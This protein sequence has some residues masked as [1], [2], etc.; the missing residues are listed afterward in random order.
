MR[1]APLALAALSLLLLAPTL[2]RSEPQNGGAA[3]SLHH[4]GI[5]VPF[6]IAPQP[7]SGALI[8]NADTRNGAADFFAQRVDRHGRRQLGDGGVLVLS[9]IGS[10]SYGNAI[11][12]GSGGILITWTQNN[13]ASGMDVYVQRVLADGS[14]A[15]GPGGLLVCNAAFDQIYPTLVAGTAGSYYVVW[16]D[17]RANVANVSDVYVQRLSLAG[18]AAFAVNGLLV[19]SVAYRPASYAYTNAAPDLSGGVLFAWNVYSP[20]GLRAQRVSSAGALLYTATGVPLGDPGDYSATIAPDGSGGLWAFTTR[21]S[22]GYYTPYAHHLTSTGASTFAA[23]GIAFHSAV[24][25]YFN[26]SLVRNASGGCFFYG[27]YYY[28]GSS[29]ISYGLFRQEITLSGT[30]PRGPDGE[31]LSG[32][33]LYYLLVDAGPCV[34]L[35]TLHDDTGYGTRYMR[36]QKYAFDGTPAFPGLGLL[37]GRA[38]TLQSTTAATSAATASGLFFDAHA[39]GRYSSPSDPFNFEVFGQAFGASGNALWDDAE[40]PV[41]EFAQDAPGDQGGFV[42][43]GWDASAADAPSSHAI[44]S[45]RGWRALGAATAAR[46]ALKARFAPDEVFAVDG[47]QYVVHAGLYWEKVADAV[48]A[49]LPSY[50]LTVPT[51]QDSTAGGSADESFMIEARDDS[52][53]HWWSA[54]LTTHSL[55]N[56]APATPHPFTGDYAGGAAHLYWDPNTETDLAGY[57]LYRGSSA[58]FVPGPSNLVASPPSPGW[59]DAS[60]PAVYKLT[61]IDTHGNESPPAV[62]LPAGATGVGDDAPRTLAFELASPN[63]SRNGATLRLALPAAS[64]VRLA[65]FDAAGREVRVLADGPM[66]AGTKSFAWDGADAAGRATASGLFFAR[67]ET[68]GRMLTRRLVRVR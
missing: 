18:S 40:N 3:I 15:Y 59:I 37:L 58:G 16:T 66:S 4:V 24:T 13:A 20:G 34:M 33:N 10:S 19:N 22:G 36:I 65:I 67:L 14:V 9:G 63:P 8:L 52:L 49:Q 27:T 39:D 41:L 2:A 51:G 6:A 55:D 64:H 54:A 23:A 62:L 7:D 56:L 11:P 35:T 12:D 1:A 5:R 26:L 25:G 32:N 43:L 28:S 47:T 50:A 53:H 31:S 61:A 21:S 38:R 44:T 42:R 46:L 29:T 48:A 68:D 57:R 17:R 30:L 60:A 45:Y